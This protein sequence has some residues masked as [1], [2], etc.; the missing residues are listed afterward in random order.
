MANLHDIERRIN[1]VESTKQITR[2]MQMVAAAKI[3]HSMERISIQPLIVM[4]CTSCSLTCPLLGR[5][6]N[7]KL[8]KP[9]DEIKNTLLIVVTSDRGLAERLQLQRSAPCR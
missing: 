9:H 5:E 4:R 3:R 8:T 2:T 6:S 1:S 7:A